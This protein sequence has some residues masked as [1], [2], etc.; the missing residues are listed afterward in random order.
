MASAWFV[1]TGPALAATVVGALLGAWDGSAADVESRAAQTHLALFVVQGLLLTGVISELRAA[2]LVA[3]GRARLAQDARHESEAA[4]RMKDEFLATISHELRTP[5]NAILGWVNL[6]RTGKL[7]SATTVRGLESID[8]NVRLQAQLTTDLLDV[9][10]ALTGKLRLESRCVSVLEATR[11]AAAAVVSSAQAKGVVVKTKFPDEEVS[12]LGDATRLRQIVWH[13]LANA[14]KFTPRGG[15]VVVDIRTSREHVIL[16]VYDS[17]PGIAPQFLPRIFDR[18]TQEDASP[19]RSAGG[20]GVGLSLVRELVELHGGEIHARNREDRHRSD[21][22]RDF[23]V[24]AGRASA[25]DRLSGLAENWRVLS[26]ARRP[27]S[28]GRRP[29]RRGSRT[30][31]NGSAA[32]GCNRADD[33]KRGRCTRGAGGVAAGCAHHRQCVTGAGLVCAHWQGPMAGSRPRRPHTRR[34]TDGLFA[35]G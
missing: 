28:I 11:E 6:L 8:R 1:G 15:T 12:V 7:D 24:A 3:E 26:S 9:S 4:S 33:G 19:T 21:L 23:S 29:R 2:R 13:L 31:A 18:F 20:L 25:S 10:K 34:R 14:I 16:T 17:G 27:A 22:Y 32:A 35:N 5:L 30:A